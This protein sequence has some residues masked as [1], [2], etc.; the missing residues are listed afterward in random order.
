MRGERFEG[1]SLRI[2]AFDDLMRLEIR[3]ASHASGGKATAHLTSDAAVDP[4]TGRIGIDLA[5]TVSFKKADC[6]KIPAA[7]SERVAGDSVWY[8]HLVLRDLTTDGLPDSLQLVASGQRPESLRITFT[9]T[10][11]G[12]TRYQA[13][14]RSQWYF[15][16]ERPIDSIPEAEQTKHVNDHLH[17]FFQ[18]QAFGRLNPADSW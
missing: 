10:S 8:R 17:E 9:I 5:R 6:E 14:W 13:V 18:P 11:G 2:S 16:Y 15:I 1:D 12:A 7:W 3:T 4:G